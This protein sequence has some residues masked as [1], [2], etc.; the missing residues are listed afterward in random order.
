MIPFDEI[1][2]RL[3]R[4]GKNRAWLAEASGRSPGSIRAALAPNGPEKQRTKLLQKAL[5]DAI[6]RE[7]L[8]LA[9]D[10]VVPPASLPDRITIEC[11]PAER[12]AW[13]EAAL[14]SGQ[15]L[16]R[17]AVDSLNRAAASEA[18]NLPHAGRPHESASPHAPE[19]DAMAG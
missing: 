5:S 15:T 14:H 18:E 4:L 12:R 17:W 10:V 3:E 6:E 8:R 7:E 2:Q 1:D 16:D 13:N 19:S 11:E 9:A